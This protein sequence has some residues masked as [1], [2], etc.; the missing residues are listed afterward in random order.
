MIGGFCD[1]FNTYSI[2]ADIEMQ[3]KKLNPFNR[4]WILSQFELLEIDF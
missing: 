1:T 3:Q 4:F 2:V